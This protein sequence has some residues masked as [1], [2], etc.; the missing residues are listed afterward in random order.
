MSRSAA[1]PRRCASREE[2]TRVVRANGAFEAVQ[3]QQARSARRGIEAMEI[4]KIIVV[5]VP[6]LAACAE[7]GPRAHEFSPERAQVRSGNPPCGPIC[8]GGHDQSYERIACN[9]WECGVESV[10]FSMDVQIFGVK[11]NPETR[12]ALR[13]FAERRVKT[14]FVDLTER[15]A[16]LGELRRF[17]QKF[18]V[19]A[20]IDESSKRFRRSRAAEL[21]H[22][23]RSVARAAGRRAAAC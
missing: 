17:A 21:A 5:G 10:Y 23:R 19:S 13:F 12:K 6:A 4:E 20:L 11:K 2:S 22:V 8:A 14:H 9:A 18:G 3:D 1:H 15:A 7:R 16:S